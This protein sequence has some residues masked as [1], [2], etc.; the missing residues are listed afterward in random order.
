MLWISFAFLILLGFLIYKWATK[1]NNYFKVRNIA[2][3]EP[4]AFF[5]TGRDLILGKLSLPDFIK[6][7]YEEFPNE[8]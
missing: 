1:N 6:K 4:I 7:C 2:Y 5:G 3:I 8:K